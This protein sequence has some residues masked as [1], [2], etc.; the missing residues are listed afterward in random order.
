MT[1]NVKR[2]ILTTTAL[3]I[4]LAARAQSA[5]A[6]IGQWQDE[7][8]PDRQ[9]EFYLDKDGL[10]Y[11]KTINSKRKEMINGQVLVK[12]LKY[13]E[14]TK[15]FK[16]LMSPPDAKLEL[17]VTISFSGQDKLKIVAKKF[18]MTKTLQLVRIK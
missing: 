6:I 4:M 5:S 9:M 16:G 2:T 15:T 12:K 17:N 14:A 18:V 10:Y 3:L 7:K 1:Q 8:E 13:D 11:A